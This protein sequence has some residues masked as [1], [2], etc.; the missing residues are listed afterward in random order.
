MYHLHLP[1]VTPGQ[2]SSASQNFKPTVTATA[3]ENGFVLEKALVLILVCGLGTIL[4]LTFVT[5][6][7]IIAVR[8]RRACLRSKH[9]YSSPK[10][11]S[12]NITERNHKMEEFDLFYATSTL[13]SNADQGEQEQQLN[14]NHHSSSFKLSPNISYSCTQNWREQRKE[15]I[16]EEPIHYYDDILNFQSHTDK[17]N[18]VYDRLASKNPDKFSMHS[19][20]NTTL[21]LKMK[22]QTSISQ[23]YMD[24][25]LTS[26]PNI[27]N[28]TSGQLKE[29]DYYVNEFD[30]PLKTRYPNY[31]DVLPT[32]MTSSQASL[33][34]V[35]L[36]SPQTEF[37][38]EYEIP[39]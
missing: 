9:I 28:T 32:P 27:E 17:N 30:G 13:V 20:E 10:H 8:K 38:N 1:A 18:G 19:Y 12:L 11:R 21:K 26:H 39:V 2:Y 35:Q 4:L 7:V 25:T 29:S 22:C 31:D 16:E 14:L 23:L 37:A 36:I 6:A 33:R 5:I 3:D 34:C 15:T 24:D